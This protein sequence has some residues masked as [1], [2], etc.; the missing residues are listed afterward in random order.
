M[1]YEFFTSGFSSVVTHKMDKW[2]KDIPS[3]KLNIE[4]T[5]SKS[6]NH[7]KDGA[8][9]PKTNFTTHLNKEIDP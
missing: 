1:I 3:K 4:E 5:T 7:W 9:I 6:T 8:S 2:L